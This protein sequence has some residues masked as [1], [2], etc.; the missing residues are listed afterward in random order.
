MKGTKKGDVA[1]KTLLVILAL[2]I[3]GSTYAG[4]GTTTKNVGCYGYNTTMPA[5]ILT[6]ITA[7]S[8]SSGNASNTGTNDGATKSWFNSINQ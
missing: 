6:N 1:M 4:W 8:K 7:L 3:S 5:D 2:L